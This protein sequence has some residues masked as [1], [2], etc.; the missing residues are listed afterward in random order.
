MDKEV[1]AIKVVREVISFISTGVYAV[2]KKLPAERKLCETLG[3]SRGTLRQGLADLESL[4]V[5]KIMP[6]S[7]AYVKKYSDKKLPGKVLPPNFREVSL[8]DIINARKII[9]LPALEIACKNATK[10]GINALNALVDKMEKAIDNLPKFLE[11]DAKFHQ[12]IV[13][14]SKNLVLATAFESISEYL[15]YSQVYSSIHEGEEEKALD[16]HKKIFKSVKNRDARGGMKMLERHLDEI[17]K[18]SK[19]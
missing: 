1:L 4:G 10:A 11:Y 5:I 13:S 7:G 18:S 17:I 14:M 8:A 9:E 15:K 16:F 19:L 3:V 12:A 6:R 2:G